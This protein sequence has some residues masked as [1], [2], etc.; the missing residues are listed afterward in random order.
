MDWL[1]DERTGC[2]SV[3]A[4]VSIKDYLE[5]AGEA[6]ARKGMIAGQREV[7]R[8]TTAKRIRERMVADITR[9]AILP[10]PVIGIT[11]SKET[12][13]KINPDEKTTIRDLF[14]KLSPNEISII[15]GMQRTQAI[16]DACER[17]DNIFERDMRVE[18][19]IADSVRPLIYRMLILNSG[20]V[21]WTLSRQLSIV[22]EPLMQEIRSNVPEI[23]RILTPETGGRRVAPA[24]YR[25]DDLVELYTAFS[26]RKTSVD[27]KEALSDEFSKL[28]FVD[29]LSSQDFQDQFYSVLKMLATIDIAFS[30]FDGAGDGR[31]E[32]GRNLFDG[33]PARVGLIVA[34][35]LYIIGRPGMERSQEERAKR[36]QKIVARTEQF[37]SML[38]ELGPEKL[39]EFLSLP[40]LNEVLDKRVGQVGRYERS[41]FSE[42]FAVLIQEGFDVPSMEPCWRAA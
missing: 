19:W 39:G 37:T 16:I 27:T 12:F 11:V 9:G 20:Q 21:P 26:L 7:L 33:Q 10:A 1:R 6:H 35:S 8:T 25:S 17:D 41:V 36:T 24:E 34:A 22:F 23:S 29:N 42:A 40:V 5:L 18:L 3:L 2:F 38:K 13:K 30:R 15:D 31:F 4:R 14:T 28:D 32:K